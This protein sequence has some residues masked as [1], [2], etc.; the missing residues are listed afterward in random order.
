M[1]D[2]VPALTMIGSALIIGA[3]VVR[4]GPVGKALAQWVARCRGAERL[5][6]P[7]GGAR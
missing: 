5:A 4:R 3:T 1:G 2:S 7:G 6:L